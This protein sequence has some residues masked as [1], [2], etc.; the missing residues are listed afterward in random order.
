MKFC[1]K[2]YTAWFTWNATPR[3][4]LTAG[5][6]KILISKLTPWS[7]RTPE[8]VPKKFHPANVKTFLNIPLL[9][10]KLNFA[11]GNLLEQYIPYIILSIKAIINN[12]KI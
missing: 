5:P 8:P 2:P 9:N 1:T 11:S 3:A 4:A 6:Q 10:E 12:N 7:L